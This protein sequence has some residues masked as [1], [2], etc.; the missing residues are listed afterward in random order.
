MQYE[1]IPIETEMK[2]K[3]VDIEQ[4]AREIRV[5]IPAFIESFTIMENFVAGLDQRLKKFE[6]RRRPKKIILGVRKPLA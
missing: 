1:Y 4:L 2:R 3:K 6:R 5:F